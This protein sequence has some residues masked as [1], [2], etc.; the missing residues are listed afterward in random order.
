M[1]NFIYIPT[2]IIDHSTQYSIENENAYI[3]TNNSSQVEFVK[4]H[5]ICNGKMMLRFCSF[6]VKISTKK[7]RRESCVMHYDQ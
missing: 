6:A 3:V 5:E 1:L 4:K 2:F 7:R